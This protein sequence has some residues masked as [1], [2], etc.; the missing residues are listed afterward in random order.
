[1]TRQYS[2]IALDNP[3]HGINVGA[4]MRAAGCYGASFVAASG[5][6]YRPGPTDVN[7]DYLN[8]PLLYD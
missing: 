8:I 7:R 3:K 2:V 6:R 1:M 5:K 4:V